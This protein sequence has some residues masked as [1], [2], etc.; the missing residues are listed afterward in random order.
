MHASWRWGCQTAAG[1][2]NVRFLP[3]MPEIPLSICQGSLSNQF[4]RSSQIQS[5]R[6]PLCCNCQLMTA[7]HR[8]HFH[9]KTIAASAHL[10][11][12]PIQ[13][14]FHRLV[15]ILQVPTPNMSRRS[16]RLQFKTHESWKW[17]RWSYVLRRNS[18][19]IKPLPY[20]P[21]LTAW[22]PL[23][24]HLHEASTLP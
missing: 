23:S 10:V 11:F 2:K 9:T 1:I 12:A 22:L 8:T 21:S 5:R 6:D 17:S 19:F 20:L 15:G 16:K 3:D 13:V 7:A 24:P 14:Q 4:D 18:W